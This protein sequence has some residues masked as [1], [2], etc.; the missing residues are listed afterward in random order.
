[1]I[2]VKTIKKAMQMRSCDYEAPS[3]GSSPGKDEKLCGKIARRK[4]RCP[5]AMM[6]TSNGREAARTIGCADKT[7]G[8]RATV[9]KKRRPNE[10]L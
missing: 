4:M 8:R 9:E 3:S 10:G 7:R 2:I 5:T 6:M 1:M